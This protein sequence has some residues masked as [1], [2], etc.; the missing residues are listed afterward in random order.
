MRKKRL[1]VRIAVPMLLC[2]A[3]FFSFAQTRI[4]SGKVTDSKDGSPVQGVSVVRKG[5]VKGTITGSDGTYRLSISDKTKTLVFSSIGFG[6]KELPV[7]GDE[8]NI[9]L[10]STNAAL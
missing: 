8:I 1:L 4:V 6:S 5:S 10:E 7:S 2:F 9:S 3:S